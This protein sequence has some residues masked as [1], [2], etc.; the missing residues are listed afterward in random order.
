MKYGYDEITQAVRLNDSMSSIQEIPEIFKSFDVD[1]D[2]AQKVAFA[3][4]EMVMATVPGAK[5]PFVKLACA[6]SFLDGF[7]AALHMLEQALT[8]PDGA[9]T[10]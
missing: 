10:K 9:A 2:A 3:R 6:A 4:A 1:E 7:A 5:D 8:N